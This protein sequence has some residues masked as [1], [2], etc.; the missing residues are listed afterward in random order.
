MTDTVGNY[1]TY[2]NIKFN[3]QSCIMR[4]LVLKSNRENYLVLRSEL[5]LFFVIM[6]TS[7]S[8]VTDELSISDDNCALSTLP[9][10]FL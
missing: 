4:M 7:L 10:R 6:S 5:Y 8:S 3:I 2:H 1:D 9:T